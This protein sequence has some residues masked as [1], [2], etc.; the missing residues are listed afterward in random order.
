MRVR[1]WT[2]AR[3]VSRA[4]LACL[5]QRGV[6]TADRRRGDP[7]GLQRFV[8]VQG[9]IRARLI[10]AQADASGEDDGAAQ[11]MRKVVR[12]P[13]RLLLVEREPLAAHEA[14]RSAAWRRCLKAGGPFILR[15]R[16][17][18]AQDERDHMTCRSSFDFV[19]ATLGTNGTTDF[20]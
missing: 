20:R 9:R 11:G 5:A 14:C 15:L 1:P 7:V 16:Y 8:L 19:T 12:H 2:S 10:R 6:D 13:G 17:R 4:S 18:Y 3:A